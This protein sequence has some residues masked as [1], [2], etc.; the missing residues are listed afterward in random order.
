MSLEPE[1]DARS[2]DNVSVDDRRRSERV[3]MR[4]PLTMSVDTSSLEGTTDNLSSI[5]VLF[6]T[7]EPLR[8]SIEVEVDGKP[9]Q[10]S[11]RL[12]RVQRMSDQSTGF[13]VEFEPES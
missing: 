4:A 8:V 12:V 1:Q 7:Q 13:A 9:Q 10:F 3:P 11:G 6:F 2:Q 5:G